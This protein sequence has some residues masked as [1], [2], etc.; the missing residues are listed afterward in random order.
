[1]KVVINLLIALVLIAG[2]GIASIKHTIYHLDQYDIYGS[3]DG[4]TLDR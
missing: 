1:M 3:S 4:V 2:Y